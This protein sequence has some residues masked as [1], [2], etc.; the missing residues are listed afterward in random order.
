MYW[1]YILT[2]IYVSNHIDKVVIMLY[3]SI[4]CNDCPFTFPQEIQM[5]KSIAD[6]YTLALKTFSV[7]WMLGVVIF[8]AALGRLFEISNDTATWIVLICG[9][10]GAVIFLMTWVSHE[11]AW[12]EK[13]SNTQMGFSLMTFG[14][15]IIAFYALVTAYGVMQLPKVLPFIGIIFLLLGFLACVWFT[16]T[17]PKKP[18]R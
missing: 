1:I 11:K 5:I 12:P 17:K 6:V 18:V 15:S 7:I 13:P 8:M 16:W 14:S 9:F 2:R 3:N 10:T 4:L